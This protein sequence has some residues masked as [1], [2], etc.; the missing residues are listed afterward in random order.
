MQQAYI[1]LILTEWFFFSKVKPFYLQF[2]HT[3]MCREKGLPWNKKG[4]PGSLMSGFFNAYI[5]ALKQNIRKEMKA[6]SEY[7]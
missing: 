6:F 7:I 3:K 2:V 5:Q 4:H 1:Y